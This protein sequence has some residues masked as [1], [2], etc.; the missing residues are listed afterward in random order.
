MVD[1]QFDSQTIKLRVNYQI[2]SWLSIWKLTIN[3]KVDYQFQSWL[4]IWK[5]IVDYQLG[6]ILIKFSSRW[7]FHNFM[8]FHLGIALK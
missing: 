3:M 2:E 8:K 6:S 5:L 4:S 1:Y 7:Q